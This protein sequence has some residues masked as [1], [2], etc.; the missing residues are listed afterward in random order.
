MCTPGLIFWIQVLGYKP[1][2]QCSVK[3]S[4]SLTIGI[5]AYLCVFP[6][7]MQL[8]DDVEGKQKYSQFAG[9]ILANYGRGGFVLNVIANNLCNTS[10]KLLEEVRT[11]ADF[12]GY[13]M[14]LAQPVESG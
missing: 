2:D 4:S 14:S 8:S 6:V 7:L 13:G 10:G 1:R 9:Q 12:Q 11:I 3:V 5:S